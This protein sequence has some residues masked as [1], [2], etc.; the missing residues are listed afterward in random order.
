MTWS[1]DMTG[2]YLLIGTVLINIFYYSRFLPLTRYKSPSK[3]S[4]GYPVS[5]IVCAKNE[6]E[7]LDQHIP[8]W[9][10]QNHPDFELILINDRSSDNSLE[11]MEK[12]ESQDERICIVDVQENETFWANKKYALTLGIK[13]A[14]HP[15]L[16]FTDA[17]CRPSSSSWLGKVSAQLDRQHRLVLGYGPY[18]SKPGLLNLLIRYETGITAIQ[19]LNA[20]LRGK[21]YMGVGRN[22]G[23]TS[24]LFFEQSGFM[25]HME[26]ASGDDDL[27]VNQASTKDNTVICID[28]DAF[29]YS[30][31]KTQPG[32]WFN[33][34][35]RH[36]TTSA[37]YK[38]SQKF[39][40][41]LYF[42]ANWAFLP[43]AIVC[44]ILYP[45]WWPLSIVLLRLSVQYLVTGFC[46]KQ[47]GEKSLTP[48]I[49]LLEPLLVWSQLF[50]FISNLMAKPKRWK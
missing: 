36:I 34:K 48:W 44:F 22:M 7:Q 10:Q 26:L 40:L 29:T 25:N 27:F 13:R 11:V 1:A 5:L 18:E 32:E 12:W 24:E 20:A 4:K 8:L 19:Y 21:A 45:W 38:P 49:L 33:Q 17:D 43:L 9:L 16:V 2:L 31:P 28:Q 50:I 47:L 37:H 3:P 42:L 35:R 30:I 46:F 6:A 41:G 14:K 39:S 23:Y 15:R